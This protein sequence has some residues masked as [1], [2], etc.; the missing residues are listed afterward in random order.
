M[1]VKRGVNEDQIVPMDHFR[2]AAIA[3][4]VGGILAVMAHDPAR[5]LDR[6]G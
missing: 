6:V 1:V 4:D 2:P 5:V 3:Q